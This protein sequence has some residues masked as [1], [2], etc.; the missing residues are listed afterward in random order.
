MPD[1]QALLI[2]C[3]GTASG[4]P[5]R[6]DDLPRGIGAGSRLPGMADQ[7]LLDGL[8]WDCCA[9][10]RRPSGG[11]AEIGRVHGAKHAT[12]AADRCSRG[13]DD[14]DTAGVRVH[15]LS[16]IFHARSGAVCARPRA[17]PAV[18]DECAN[19]S[20]GNRPF[21]QIFGFN[22]SDIRDQ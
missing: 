10:E 6:L 20:G 16:M 4:R 5:A 11:G 7:D 19:S 21:L 17:I 12:E 2:V 22:Y 8:G 18:R 13:T 15:N 14:H 3:A 9:F 1:A